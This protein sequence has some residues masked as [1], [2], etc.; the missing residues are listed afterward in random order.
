MTDKRKMN[1]S[2]LEKANLEKMQQ[3]LENLLPTPAELPASIS[4]DQ[5]EALKN[6]ILELEEKLR[7]VPGPSQVGAESAR[8]YPAASAQVEPRQDDSILSAAWWL[9]RLSYPQK[10]FIVSM[11]FVLA[12]TGFIPLV[13]DSLTRLAQYGYA[14]LHGV[15]VLQPAQDLLG[16]LQEYE[17]ALL[18]YQQG[19]SSLAQVQDAQARVEKDLLTL[20]ALENRYGDELAFEQELLALN[21]LWAIQKK[22][23]LSSDDRQVLARNAELRGAVQGLISQVGDTSFLILD[24]DLDTYY[25]MD[26]V[27]LK[28]PV[29]QE[30]L[31]D[32]SRYTER[33]SQHNA[34]SVA[35]RAELAGLVEQANTLI[36]A[37]G[38]SAD[39]SFKSNASG[40]MEPIVAAPYQDLQSAMVEFS[41]VVAEYLLNPTL[42]STSQKVFEQ[43]QSV[44]AKSSEFFTATSQALE[45]GIRDR[46]SLL[47]NRWIVATAVAFFAMSSAFMIGSMV[48]LN[49]SR[50]LAELVTASHK[51][52]AGDLSVRAPARVLDEVGMVGQAF[53]TMAEQLSGLFGLMEQRVAARTHDLELAAEV[54]RI[55]TGK[56]G[57]ME[58]MLTEAVELIRARFDLYYTQVYLVDPTGE[59]IA[60]QA[61]TGSVGQQLLNRGH[62]LP[63]S[64]ASLNGRAVTER[65][66]VIVTDTALSGTFLRNPL[67]PGTRSEMVVP[68]VVGDRVIGTLDMQ[69]ERPGSLNETNLAAFEAL[70]GQIAVAVQNA[71]LFARSEADRNQMEM[72]MSANVAKGW[73]DFLDGI[74]HKDKLGYVFNHSGV[75]ELLG[76][77]DAQAEG[78]ALS[79]PIT[80]AGARVGKIEV[81]DPEHTWTGLEA[82]VVQAV[83]GQ[84]AQHIDGL[85]LLLQADKYRVEAE[86]AANRLT[87]EGWESYLETRNRLENKGFI[88]NNNEVAPLKNHIG[89]PVGDA[90]LS[91]PIVVRDAAVGDL[92]IDL[93]D[94]N[95]A[96]VEAQGLIAEI[97]IQLGSHIENLRLL[98]Q[99]EVRRVEA[100]KLLRELDSQKFALD[101]HSI[102]GITDQ[103][104]K[105]IYANDRFVEISKY[106]R[107]ELLGQDHRILNSGYHPKEY[108]R[109]MWVTIA[110]G[111]VWHGEFLNKAK[112]GT[113]YWVESTIVP[114]LNDEGKPYRYVAIRTDITERKKAEEVIARRA[115]ELATV[116]TVSTTASTELDPD[117]LLQT[118][119]DLTQKRF[120]LYHVHIYVAD[121]TRENLRLAAGFGSVGE[122]MVA[123]GHAIPLS[124]AVSLVARAA[125]ERSAVII[126]NVRGEADF[127][128]NPLL[129]ETRSELAVPL[130][131]GDAVLGVFDIQSDKVDHFTAE[132]ATI[133]TTLAAQVA[134]A[135]QNARLFTEVAQSAERLKEVDK[136]KSEFLAN[137]SHELRTPLNSV[138]GYAEILLTGI[139]G[140]LDEEKQTDVQAIYD[141]GRHLLSLIN[142]VLDLA[143]IEAG[144]M[145]LRKEPV[146]I[147]ELLE[148]VKNT[149]FGMIHALNKSLEIVTAV[150]ADLP[151]VV[152]D[153]IRL[154]QVLN[155]L[156]SNAIKFTEK[157]VITIRAYQDEEWLSIE[158]EDEGIG[159]ARQNLQKIFER[160]S[161]VDSST[162]RRVQG[163][164][165]GLPISYRLIE[166]HGGI[167]KVESEIGRGSIFTVQLPLTQAVAVGSER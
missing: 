3:R 109:K 48:M 84:L 88:Y 20:Q 153:P 33:I 5:A 115:A 120:D 63:I 17:L 138:I 64:P 110:N 140:E 164:G 79:M 73:H 75:V 160:F 134:V 97:A 74:H 96:G 16:A 122:Q 133:Y 36:G 146:N 98:E 69:S 116:A 152:V 2:K 44:N 77:F 143:K 147:A 127:L 43:G 62:R 1:N 70:A 150:H 67:L 37:M 60:L 94:G 18:R 22:D 81:V 104:G 125:R 119:V 130:I 24:P 159:I 91:Q 85:R 131:V 95:G 107:A 7:Q 49:I 158:V 90:G 78:Q 31:W 4:I 58:A 46:I 161:Q 6:R 32:I 139:D 141:N 38:K 113:L 40:A 100:E 10:F 128:H 83:A 82:E 52:A 111:Q 132:D 92:V 129:P 157:G 155:N 12:F 27:L 124:A 51:L 156:V 149:N 53:N 101:Q 8:F 167:L 26:L 19:L 35:E 54:G 103:T 55:I 108:F 163:T 57:N 9:R 102:V 144:R 50:P 112:D 99:A 61:G 106:T 11:I 166:M 15:Y 121:N 71:I 28:Q 65:R 39:T 165:L 86:Q 34:L 137:M 87:R 148:T 45:V 105:I 13:Q 21:Q 135:L 126:N 56:I 59:T 162:T 114:F 76:G 154:S 42:N 93:A 142:D 151:R 117:K 41:G 30:T 145:V 47:R 123:A 25:M 72:N 29:L 66:S 136:M 89:H 23:S 118:V 14:E 80:V 68:L